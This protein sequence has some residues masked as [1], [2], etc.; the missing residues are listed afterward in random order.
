MRF[1]IGQ[2]PPSA[3]EFVRAISVITGVWPPNMPR[4]MHCATAPNRLSG[5]KR[6]RERIC[7]SMVS[8]SFPMGNLARIVSNGRVILA[9][10]LMAVVVV[11]NSL[12]HIGAELFYF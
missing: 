1:A 10:L 2:V 8:L 9:L 11:T 6:V 12:Y 5:N 4:M 3:F 7:T